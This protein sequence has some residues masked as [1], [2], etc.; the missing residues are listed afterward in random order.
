MK[1]FIELE[2]QL[3]QE[4][5]EFISN[6]T[7]GDSK[8]LTVYEPTLLFVEIDELERNLLVE[9][10][11]YQIILYPDGT[12]VVVSIDVDITLYTEVQFENLAIVNLECGEEALV[13]NEKWVEL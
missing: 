13:Y 12:L 8:M 11:V 1:D 2:S 7:G 4:G 5:I 6:D 9:E 3:A 10:F